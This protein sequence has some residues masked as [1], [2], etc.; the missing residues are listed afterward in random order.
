MATLTYKAKDYQDREELDRDI[1]LAHGQTT[2][3]KDAKITGTVEELLALRLS[4]GTFVWGVRAEASNY[5]ELNYPKVERGAKY[6]TKLNGR[7]V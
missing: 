3:A 5:K 1:V 2:D 7:L 6:P 4:H